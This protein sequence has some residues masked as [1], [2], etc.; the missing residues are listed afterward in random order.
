MAEKK[1]VA[2]GAAVDERV[3]AALAGLDA[4]GQL[5]KDQLIGQY[6]AAVTGPGNGKPGVVKRMDR[7]YICVIPEWLGGGTLPRKELH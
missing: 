2:G 3:K 5:H 1:A 4:I 6:D 7:R